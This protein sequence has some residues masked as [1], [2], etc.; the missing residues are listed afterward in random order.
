MPKVVREEVPSNVGYIRPISVISNSVNDQV[1]ATANSVAHMGTVYRHIDE[2][3]TATYYMYDHHTNDWLILTSDATEA[4]LKAKN[5]VRESAPWSQNRVFE[6]W[7]P[8]GRPGSSGGS[9]IR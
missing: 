5:K 8:G 1:R 7:W 4:I 9:N 6:E 2:D 3:G